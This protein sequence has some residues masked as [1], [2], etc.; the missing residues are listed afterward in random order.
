MAG[1]SCLNAACGWTMTFVQTLLTLSLEPLGVKFKS[2]NYQI[3]KDPPL[4]VLHL[5]AQSDQSGSRIQKICE[6]QD[7]NTSMKQA[8]TVRINTEV[9]I[10]HKAMD[11][12]RKL[13]T[14]C[15]ICSKAT[16]DG[17]GCLGKSCYNC[18]GDHF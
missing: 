12:I 7:I 3:R 14:T 4:S 2:K 13:Q 8:A 18:G 11:V 15:I 6:Q 17:T 5:V 10:M 16:C 1:E 9:Q